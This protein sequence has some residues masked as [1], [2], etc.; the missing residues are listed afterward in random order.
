MNLL[1]LKMIL[2]NIFKII[3]ILHLAT[4]VLCGPKNKKAK[5]EAPL[6]D[7]EQERQS[8]SNDGSSDPGSFSREQWNTVQRE[9]LSMYAQSHGLNPTFFSDN[10]LRSVL[11]DVYHP[12]ST[13]TNQND[14]P[15]SSSVSPERTQQDNGPPNT[16]S[17]STL[18]AATATATGGHQP[19]IPA[20]AIVRG[21][22]SSN[23]TQ[24]EE[25]L[26]LIEDRLVSTMSRF[27]TNNI[28]SSPA[29]P[30]STNFAQP[31]QLN[32]PS[33]SRPVQN[34]VSVP[35][36]ISPFQQ[37]QDV[38]DGR[39]QDLSN[40]QL[41]PVPANVINR[42]RRGE[43]V[44][45]DSLLPQ[46]VGR[47]TNTHI[48]LNID[49]DSISLASNNDSSS[50]TKDNSKYKAKVT[51][52]LTWSLAWTFFFQI[53]VQFNSHLTEQLLQ[54]QL[55]ITNMANQYIFSAWYNYDKA[56]RQSLA[57]NPHKVNW[58]SS[59]GYIFN[60]YVRDRNLKS[61]CFTCGSSNHLSPSCPFATGKGPGSSSGKLQ[62]FGSVQ[63]SFPRLRAPGLPP[64][65]PGSFGSNS[66]SVSAN[67]QAPS[68]Y[69]SRPPFP[70]PQRTQTASQSGQV[71][72][73]WNQ[74]QCTRYNNCKFLHVCIFCGASNHP[75]YQ[76]H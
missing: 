14:L 6:I 4:T 56:F 8:H 64:T 7:D 60:L 33:L 23:L 71:C 1:T 38:Q 75:G 5:I 74:G 17:T 45:F 11:Y 30:T 18:P 54:Y 10:T 73:R 3:T 34:N 31:T 72:R 29:L 63:Q 62:P 67:F 76:C 47:S 16:S 39:T 49:G 20:T 32:L 27:L 51:D 24:Q 28:R 53:M 22:N 41:P 21:N 46:N 42:I 58:S 50:T 36:N 12:R 57:N 69:G 68:H 15:N 43:F 2:Q 35:A 48:S 55:Y 65:P 70:A 25:L 59:D 37:Q 52:F 66:P 13:T 61:K 19:N 44:N 9:E 40:L 26:N